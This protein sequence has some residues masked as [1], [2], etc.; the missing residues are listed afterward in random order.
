MGTSIVKFLKTEAGGGVLLALAAIAALVVANSPWAATYFDTLK[1][2]WALDLGFWRTEMTIKEW[3]KDGLMALFFFVIGLELKRELVV[4]ELSDPRTVALPV[5]AAL[6][7]A[8][9]PI[10]VYL[11]IAGASD[12]RGWPVPV[13]TDI[14]FALAALALLAPKADPRLRIF[15]LTLAVVD[16]LIAIVLIA[17]LFTNDLALAPLALAMALL[18]GVWLLQRYVDLPQDVYRAVLLISWALAVESGVHSSVMAVAAAA[19]VP[20]QT[21]RARKPILEKLEHETHLASAYVVLPLFAFAAAGISFAGLGFNT[22]LAPTAI[23]VAAG[24]A[25][26]KPIGVAGAA[27]A[28]ARLLRTPDPLPFAD[29]L[30]VGCLCGIGFTMSLFIGAL[31][32]AGDSAGETLMRIG[33]IAG[34]LVALT[35]SVLLFAMR[36]NAKPQVKG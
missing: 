8:L 23:G 11:V 26:G 25:L 20:I 17:V 22:L 18:A 24:L 6:G 5:A 36:P 21:A 13:A 29:V 7:G 16:D 34:S 4:G 28:A 31:A 15:L 30:R 2:S 3:V 19:I 35:L 9:V 32:Y 14:A 10:F 1:T 33:V 12:I 27:W